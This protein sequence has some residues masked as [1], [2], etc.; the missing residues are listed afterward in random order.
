MLEAFAYYHVRYAGESVPFF[1]LEDAY[2][3]FKGLREPAALW[4]VKGTPYMILTKK[5]LVTI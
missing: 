5:A 3:F 2:E 1:S 4:G